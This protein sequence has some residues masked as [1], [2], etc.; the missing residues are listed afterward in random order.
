MQE[1]AK[2]YFSLVIVIGL[3]LGLL[4][5]SIGNSLTIFVIP[6]LFVLM[7]FTVLK[8]DF[9]KVVHSI[10]KPIPLIIA[11][12]LSYILIPAILYLITDI[13]A[14]DKEAKLSVMFSALAPTILSAPYFV[15]IMK[16]DIEFSFVL[17][18]L[19]TVMA[20]FVIPF[21]LYYI[22]GDSVNFPLIN[23]FNYIFII[24]FVPILIVQI[25]KISFPNILLISS[26]YENVV[27]AFL[28]FIFIWAIISTNSKEILNMSEF[29]L[30]LVI[31]GIIQ[32]FGFFLLLRKISN[33]F[34]SDEM[35]KSF[36]FSVAIKNTALTAGIAIL[37]SSE[38]A[39][40]S[41]IVILVH[42]PMFAWI[43]YK[44]DK[45]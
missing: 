18:I 30:I 37:T 19:V 23:I 17:S 8:V 16:G 43:M 22:F 44:K 36:A 12:I 6:S 15:S 26:N 39:L 34:L 1:I 13:F 21:E 3:V 35:S 41:S 14:L 2:K 9:Y 5:P 29:V 33:I 10:K 20:P 38:L 31:I 11:V 45:I 28:F 27:T 24:V 32:E 4:V 42:V 40:A 7:L 25:L